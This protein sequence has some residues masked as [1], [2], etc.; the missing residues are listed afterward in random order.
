M[1]PRWGVYLSFL[2]VTP[3]SR[4]RTL[5][6]LFELTLRPSRALN[7][8][9]CVAYGTSELQGRQVCRAGRKFPRTPSKTTD[10][11]L[12]GLLVENNFFPMIFNCKKPKEY[13]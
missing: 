13:N 3:S 10:T 7:L 11:N 9:L 2:P 4:S 8:T 1:T 6:G 12:D 5:E